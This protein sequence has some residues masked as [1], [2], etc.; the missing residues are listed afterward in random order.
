MM[1][2]ENARLQAV[3]A[4]GCAVGFL[5]VFVGAGLGGT[6]RHGVN[7]AASWLGYTAF[8]AATLAIN[9][10]GSFVMGLLAGYLTMRGH[11]PQH[12]R[13]FL[14]TGILGGFTTFSAFSLDAAS[15]IQRDR[16]GLAAAY[17]GGSV[18]LSITAVFAGLALSRS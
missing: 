4:K 5:M 6:L 14:T 16:F 3:A 18:I 7:L 15:L 13:L 9:V 1:R 2:Q 12:V 8:P 10:V 17:I 11:V